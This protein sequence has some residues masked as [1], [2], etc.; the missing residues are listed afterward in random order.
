MDDSEKYM[1][2]INGFLHLKSVLSPEDVACC[3]AAIDHH[4]GSAAVYGAASEKGPGN[5]LS[6]GACAH[7][8]P[9]LL[10]CVPK[11][12]AAG[13]E[14]LRGTTGRSDLGNFIGWERP[15]R[16]PFR[17]LMVHPR[18]VGVLNEILGKGFRLDHGSAPCKTPSLRWCDRDPSGATG[19]GLIMMQKGSEGHTLHGSSG[20]GFDQHQYYI[21]RDGKMHCGLTVVAWQFAD[22]NPGDGGEGRSAEHHVVR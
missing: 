13:S 19:F 9:G 20:P 1:F 3:N 12:A 21:H 2:D 15:W 5:V 11:G 4:K 22:V 6:G 8:Y 10:S 18:I 17:D 7:K 14:A 16:D